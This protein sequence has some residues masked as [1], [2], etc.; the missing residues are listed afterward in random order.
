MATRLLN[1]YQVSSKDSIENEKNLKVDVILDETEEVPKLGVPLN[2]SPG[3]DDN[4][5]EFSRLWNFW[6]EPKIDLDAIAT[7]LSVFDDKTTL[8]I[9]RPPPEYE[10][11]HRFDPLARWTWREEKVSISNHRFTKFNALS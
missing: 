8:E 9:Y 5:V 4:Q 1:R 6:R 2:S 7:Q 10:N 3:G 11:V